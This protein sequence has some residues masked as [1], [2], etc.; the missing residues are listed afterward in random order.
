MN[1]YR[2]P[3]WS[4]VVAG[5]GIFLLYV[6]TLSPSTAMWDASEYIATAH[7][8]GIP[9]PP[10]NPLFVVLGRAWS[11]L[12]SPLGLSVAVRI[13]LLA[14]FTSAAAAGFYFLVTHRI[15]WGIMEKGEGGPTDARKSSRNS[16]PLM[17]AALAVLLS[18]TAF[19]V[20]NQSN[21]NEKVYTVS[22]L[23]IAT[24]VWLA[25]RWR[26]RRDEPQGLR[27]L[28]WAVYLLALGSTNHLMSVLP[29]PALG[30]FILLVSPAVLLNKDL[31][32]RAVPLVILGLSF[33]FFLPIR[34]AE[35]PVIN[36]GDP[37]CE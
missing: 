18:G 19:T 33:N 7:I 5:G 29:L 20:W 27:Y 35:D 1:D 10:G 34:A 6:L 21:V 26:D 30:L 14:A 12:L 16:L 8:L 17:G 23:V 24:V 9:H 22:V 37:A 28:L 32:I 36:E 3:Y 31:W 2:P 15:L 4:A 11:L 25:F 13:N